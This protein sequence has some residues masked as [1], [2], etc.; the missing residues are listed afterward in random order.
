LPT[1][2]SR[3]SRAR[4][5]ATSAIALEGGQ[6]CSRRWLR[7]FMNPDQNR[8]HRLRILPKPIGNGHPLF[9]HGTFC[10]CSNKRASQWSV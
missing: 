6:P 5:Q 7:G 4:E 1:A 10:T 3:A 8:I 2:A 9:C